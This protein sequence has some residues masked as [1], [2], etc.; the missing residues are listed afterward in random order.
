MSGTSYQGSIRSILQHDINK[1]SA[2]RR[3]KKT[4]TTT[5]IM[6]QRNILLTFQSVQDS[7]VA[8]S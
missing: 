2:S 7:G 4:V 1:S 3:E 8:L 6:K 5:A